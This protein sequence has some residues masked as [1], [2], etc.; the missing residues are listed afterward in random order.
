MYL[1]NI[2]FRVGYIK[3]SFKKGCHDGYFLLGFAFL[4][5]RYKVLLIL[6]LAAIH[7][8]SILYDIPSY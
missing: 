2:L 7:L 3:F 5:Q 8:F 4:I 1:K 6:T